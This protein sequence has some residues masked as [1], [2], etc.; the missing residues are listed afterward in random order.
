MLYLFSIA[1]P[2]PFGHNCYSTESSK[3]SE[4]RQTRVLTPEN[5]HKYN[6]YSVV[7]CVACTI[8]MEFNYTFSGDWSD[9]LR[10]NGSRAVVVSFGPVVDLRSA[11]PPGGNKIKFPLFHDCCWSAVDDDD[12]CFFLSFISASPHQEDSFCSANHS[13]DRHTKISH[14]SSIQSLHLFIFARPLCVPSLP[15]WPISS[16]SS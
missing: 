6:L 7:V 12:E 16:G 10:F 14:L 5:D 3:Q 9:R 8:Q 4:P 11:R 2:S 15:P 1:Y 13:L